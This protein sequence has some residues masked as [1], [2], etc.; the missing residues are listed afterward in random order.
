MLRFLLV[1]AITAPALAQDAPTTVDPTVRTSGTVSSDSIEN[2]VVLTYDGFGVPTVV[3]K[4][5]ADAYFAEGFLHAQNRFTQMDLI[6][7]FAAGELCE[8]VGAS[9]Y[10]QDV[11]MRSLRLRSVARAC[12]EG[13]DE[14]ER[15][16]MKR[17]VDGVNAGLTDL[18]VP[19]PEYA[20][21][22]VSPEAWE[23]ED[24]ILVMLAY[25]VMLDR[26]GAMEIRD[27]AMFE[28]LPVE[29]RDFL[30]SPLSRFDAP[31]PG[32]EARK[33]SIPRIPDR[34]VISLREL[35]EQPPVIEYRYDMGDDD[36]G[37]G[38]PGGAGDSDEPK[39]PAEPSEEQSKSDGDRRLDS[40]RTTPGSNNWG[41]SG[42]LT[43]DG[44]AILASDPHLQ[45][46]VR[47]P[48]RWG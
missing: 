31:I 18:Q 36:D 15:L 11:E 33:P 40:E 21:L 20:I 28:S 39:T 13:F 44:R 9:A 30:Y 46:R 4:S 16:L 35:P 24:T 19:P 2:E 37:P 38:G 17:Y 32:L 8:L 6:R 22:R 41:V 27:A 23:M 45:H 3:A 42:R 5:R 25:S 14:T 48:A 7:R 26:T 43:H 29:V 12:V 10:D 1:L 47:V 34:K